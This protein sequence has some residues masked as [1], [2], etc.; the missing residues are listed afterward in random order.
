MPT[1]FMHAPPIG[2]QP[3]CDN[4]P[5][6]RSVTTFFHQRPPSRLHVT[7]FPQSADTD[8]EAVTTSRLRPARPQAQRC[9]RGAAMWRNPCCREGTPRITRART[10]GASAVR[11]DAPPSRRSVRL[12]IAEKLKEPQTP[13]GAAPRPFGAYDIVQRSIEGGS[14]DEAALSVVRGVRAPTGGYLTPSVVMSR[15]AYSAATAGDGFAA[16]GL[17]G[18]GDDSLAQFRQ[19]RKL[20]RRQGRN[21][22]VHLR[23]GLLLL[24]RA[25]TSALRQDHLEDDAHRPLEQF[26]TG[27]RRHAERGQSQEQPLCEQGLQNG[28]RRQLEN[29]ELG[30]DRSSVQASAQMGSACARSPRRWE[31]A[32]RRH[33]AVQAE[34][35]K[36]AAYLRNCSSR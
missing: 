18:L 6:K 10:L 17:N 14:R 13:K 28:V 5:E 31:S 15:S 35:G 1:D 3:D 7:T 22:L 32:R 8:G 11:V 16:P 29:D 33:P 27:L 12:P 20:R 30:D 36:P 4:P 9:A 25:G 26:W 19:V 21:R 24:R 23:R 2:G 34:G